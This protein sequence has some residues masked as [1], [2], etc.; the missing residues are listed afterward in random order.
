MENADSLAAVK[1][2]VFY[3]KKYTM[4]Q[5]ATAMEANWEG[6]EEMRLDFVKNAPKWGN[7]DDY[8]DDLMVRCLRECA[9]FSK[10]LKCPSGNNWPIFRRT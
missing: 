9:C 7:D 2:L 6:Y 4:D 10:V 5:L 3:D 1:K 8:V